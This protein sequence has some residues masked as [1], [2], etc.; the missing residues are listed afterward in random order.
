MK[1]SKQAWINKY[2]GIELIRSEGMMVVPCINCDDTICHGW[3][4]TPIYRSINLE[5]IIPHR[6]IDVTGSSFYDVT[7]ILV[8]NET[9]P[10]YHFELMG[11]D[12]TCVNDGSGI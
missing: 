2:G 12:D 8:T 3:K 1:L 11:F 9:L 7:K 6:Q 10:S 5:K 4:L